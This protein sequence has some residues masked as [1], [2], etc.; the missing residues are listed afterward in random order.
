MFL[1]IY[2]GEDMKKCVTKP[3]KR[4]TVN[5]MNYTNKNIVP[6]KNTSLP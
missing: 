4:L 3:L 5:N 2:I 6:N 1:S